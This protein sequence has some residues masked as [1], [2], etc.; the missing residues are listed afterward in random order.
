[1]SGFESLDEPFALTRS[2]KN[3]FASQLSLIN[4]HQEHELQKFTT[5]INSVIQ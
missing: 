4:T 2:D 5:T 1:M 3:I